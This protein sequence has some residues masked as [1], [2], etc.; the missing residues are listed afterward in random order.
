MLANDVIRELKS[1][2]NST[3]AHE[4]QR[5]FQTGPGQYGEGDI[6]LGLRVPQVRAVAKTYSTLELMEV[7]KLMQSELH[8]IRLCGV[9]L[10]ANQFKAS[11]D[12]RTRK[13]I[14]DI[15]VKAT[16]DGYVNNWDLVD[17]SAPTIGVYLLGI[18]NPMPTLV[19]LAKS[20]GLW[21]RRLA[22]LFTF[23]FIRA[24]EY[25]PTLIIAEILLK[26]P[27]DLIHKAVGWM[28]R[29]VGN[30]NPIILR[31]FLEQNYQ[32]MP[33]TALRYAIEKL[34]KRERKA[35]LNRK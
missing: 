19:K 24:G 16:S 10:L 33:R 9:I 8:E 30:R 4:L 20:K 14:F 23:A 5:F 27:H 13:Q 3:R 32:E 28:L 12:P 25:E 34:P 35:W 18:S 29:E 6:F 17:V 1:L 26:D 7:G 31:N 15:Y 22:V 11:H 21:E 2:K